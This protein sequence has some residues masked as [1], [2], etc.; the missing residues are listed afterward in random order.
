MLFQALHDLNNDRIPCARGDRIEQR[1][2]LIVTGNLF[3]AQQGVG[4][5]LT[6]VLLQGALVISKR[7]R[8]GQEDAKGTESGILDTVSGVWPGFARI[9]QGIDVSMDDALESIEI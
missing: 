2:D 3:D 5:V 7:R 8:L 1:A 6:G 9:R 4:V